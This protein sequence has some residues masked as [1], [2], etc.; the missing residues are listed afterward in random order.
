MYGTRDHVDAICTCAV[1]YPKR[2][3][4]SRGQAALPSSNKCQ[5]EVS[6]DKTTVKRECSLNLLCSDVHRDRKNYAV[7][8]G[9]T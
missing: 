3:V 6:S 8:K 1:N 7:S 9:L 4:R 2:I 5:A